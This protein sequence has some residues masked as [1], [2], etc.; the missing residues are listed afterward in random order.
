M[1]LD[2]IYQAIDS[3]KVVHWENSLYELKPVKAEAGNKYAAPSYREGKALRIT[4]KSNGFGSLITEKCFEK[5][6]IKQ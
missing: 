6:F 1:T 5:C 2:E 4:C 3:G